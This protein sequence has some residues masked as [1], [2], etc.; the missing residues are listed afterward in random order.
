MNGAPFSNTSTSLAAAAAVRASRGDKRMKVLEAIRRASQHGDGRTAN[1]LV[2]FLD[3]GVQSVTA[4]IRGLVLDGLVVDRGR[5]RPSRPGSKLLA[6][7]WEAAPPGMQPPQ[8]NRQTSGRLVAAISR[9]RETW[10]AKV[11]I[12]MTAL[13]QIETHLDILGRLLPAQQNFQIQ[14]RV[15]V[16][17]NTART[18]REQMRAGVDPLPLVE[19]T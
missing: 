11:A 9:E 4:R 5:R 16:T 18:A 17:L 2:A 10:R 7:V 6:I 3:I 12:A 19:R 14:E 13:E 15:R 1:E 8:R